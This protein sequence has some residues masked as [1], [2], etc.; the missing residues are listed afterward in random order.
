MRERCCCALDHPC[1]PPGIAENG[2]KHRHMGSAAPKSS[3]LRAVPAH[4]FGSM[5]GP[6]S[7]VR[8]PNFPRSFGS[9][10]PTGTGVK[11]AG[12]SGRST[13]SARLAAASHRP[14]RSRRHSTASCRQRHLQKHG[15]P[16]C[17]KCSA[18]AALRPNCH[19]RF[20]FRQATCGALPCCTP[21]NPPGRRQQQQVAQRPAR[22]S[23]LV[24]AVRHC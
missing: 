4:L 19:S 10:P 23:L 21:R 20:M 12:S 16:S 8:T 18:G 17:R 2:S 9:H 11:P 13:C 7:A 6:R 22:V 5:L 1:W 14:C 15:R 24:T 3:I